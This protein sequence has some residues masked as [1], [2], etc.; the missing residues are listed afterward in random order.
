VDEELVREF[1]A[2]LTLNELTEVFV[3]GIKVP[4]TSNAINEFFNY[5]IS[6]MMNVLP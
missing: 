3:R 5:L 4:I 1:F 2:N 6:K